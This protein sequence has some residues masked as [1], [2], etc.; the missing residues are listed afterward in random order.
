MLFSCKTIIC[1]KPG[2]SRPLG[3]PSKLIQILSD[4]KCLFRALPYA[5]TQ[6]DRYICTRVRA[7]DHEEMT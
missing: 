2:S 6:L 1:S 5:V 3:T 7:Q 4:G